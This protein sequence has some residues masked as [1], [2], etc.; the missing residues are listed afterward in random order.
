MAARGSPSSDPAADAGRGWESRPLGPGCV[1]GARAP[2]KGRP[3]RGRCGE[4]GGLG[5]GAA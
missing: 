3:A 2:A 1:Q 4:G 5:A